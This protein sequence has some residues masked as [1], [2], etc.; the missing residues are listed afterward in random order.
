MKNTTRRRLTSLKGRIECHC[1]SRTYYLLRH[2]NLDRSF[3]VC[4]HLVLPTKL[5]LSKCSVGLAHPDT[6]S[7]F[8]TGHTSIRIRI[9]PPR[10]HQTRR[11]VELVRVFTSP[12]LKFTLHARV[13]TPASVVADQ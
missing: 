5:S 9:H 10:T 3:L 1:R 13:G 12:V 4:D 6:V 7:S 8:L 2:S 11:K